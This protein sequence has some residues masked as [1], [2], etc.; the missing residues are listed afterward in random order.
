MCGMNILLN[1]LV[2]Y[3]ACWGVIYEARVACKTAGMCT[4]QMVS[5]VPRTINK[6]STQSHRHVAWTL[7]PRKLDEISINLKRFTAVLGCHD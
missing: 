7:Q 6:H 1:S 5:L 4:W 3:I 2:Q